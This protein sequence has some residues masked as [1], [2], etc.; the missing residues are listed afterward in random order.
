M[1]VLSVI[2]GIMFWDYV[3]LFDNSF[4]A[5]FTHALTTGNVEV[6]AEAG[7]RGP[8]LVEAEV[9]TEAVFIFVITRFFCYV[10]FWAFLTAF[11]PIVETVIIVV[12]LKM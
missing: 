7:G 3:S 6:E 2:L 11:W 10:P 4:L 8:F 9:E 12:N 1:L 5:I